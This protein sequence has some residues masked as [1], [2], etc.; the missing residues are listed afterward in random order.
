MADQRWPD[1]EEKKGKTWIA[2]RKVSHGLR[3]RPCY[4]FWECRGRFEETKQIRMC[5]GCLCWLGE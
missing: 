1:S 3:E 4:I 2:V 5:L